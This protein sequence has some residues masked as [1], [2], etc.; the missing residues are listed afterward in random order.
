MSAKSTPTAQRLL[1]TKDKHFHSQV[2]NLL[3]FRS[4]MRLCPGISGGPRGSSSSHS[5][6]S[7][8]LRNFR[9]HRYPGFA[10]NQD[11]SL[12]P[13]KA[14]SP[15]CFL[16]RDNELAVED[17]Q[18]PVGSDVWS[19]FGTVRFQNLNDIRDHSLSWTDLSISSSPRHLFLP[20]M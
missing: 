6:R 7:R 10:L 14:L 8:C 19:D 11:V 1:N 20:Q 15:W 16:P 13:L 4:E 3:Q 5:S 9:K 17:L 18:G 12:I 2:E